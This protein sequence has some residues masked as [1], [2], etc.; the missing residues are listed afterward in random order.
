MSNFKSKTLMVKNQG[1]VEIDCSQIA[2]LWHLAQSLPVKQGEAV[3]KIWYQA[4]AM[5]DKLIELQGA[6][7]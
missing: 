3:L 7:K 5:Q 1:G 2:D 6:G 4:H